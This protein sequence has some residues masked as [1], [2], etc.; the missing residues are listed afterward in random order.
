V[1]E[2]SL[3]LAPQSCRPQKER[4]KLCDRD[5]R[6]RLATVVREAKAHDERAVGH[7]EE[8]LAKL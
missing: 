4:L 6:D 8:A 3:R 1:L 5:R 2:P 7:L